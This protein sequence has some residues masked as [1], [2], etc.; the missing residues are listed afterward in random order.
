MQGRPAEYQTIP[1]F[2]RGESGMLPEMPVEIGTI[3]VPAGKECFS[4]IEVPV[5]QQLA[6]LLDPYLYQEL[7]KSLVG[8]EFEK[9]AKRRGSK[10]NHPRHLLQ[11]DL[12]V[13]IPCDIVEDLLELVSVLFAVDRR[14]SR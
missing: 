3:V 2:R 5:R 13:E 10:V 4:H 1:V 12:L 7:G 9:P 11:G 14:Q 6:C 8:S